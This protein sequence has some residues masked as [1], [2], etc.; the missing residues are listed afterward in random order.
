MRMEKAGAGGRGGSRPSNPNHLIFLI[1]LGR[2]THL[3][4]TYK[5]VSDQVGKFGSFG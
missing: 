1:A 2:G 3:G 5:H 4:F